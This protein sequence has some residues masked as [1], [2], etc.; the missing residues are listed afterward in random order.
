MTLKYVY[1]ICLMHIK[2]ANFNI[3]TT[4]PSAKS[5]IAGWETCIIKS[6]YIYI[7]TQYI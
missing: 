5:S 7:Y 1:I 2:Y 4:H 3:S 6:M